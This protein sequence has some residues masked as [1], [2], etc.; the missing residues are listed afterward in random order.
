MLALIEKKIVHTKNNMLSLESCLRSALP[1]YMF[2]WLQSVAA[3]YLMRQMFLE[4]ARYAI[5]ALVILWAATRHK[6]RLIHLKAGL[7]EYSRLRSLGNVACKLY[8]SAYYGL[9]H[10]AFIYIS[11]T[12]K[13]ERERGRAKEKW[14]VSKMSSMCGICARPVRIYSTAKLRHS[15]RNIAF[16]KWY[17]D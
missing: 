6:T 10:L 7:Y 5:P 14:I 17:H 2:L 9:F 12:G 1:I 3:R 8:V 13:P 15:S 4:S 16:L 11:T